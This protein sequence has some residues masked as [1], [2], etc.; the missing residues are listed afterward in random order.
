VD[1]HVPVLLTHGNYDTMRP[2]VV[3][4]MKEKLPRV[5]DIM[6]HKSG[7]LSMIDEPKVMNDAMA[8]FFNRV[9]QQEGYLPRDGDDLSMQQQ[10]EEG[11]H[12]AL[13]RPDILIVLF[14]VC[15][16][17]LFLLVR[18]VVSS[19]RRRLDYAPVVSS[20]LF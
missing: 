18:H 19:R 9:E 12:A 17:G 20:T 11:C 7:H 14:L 6:F 8:D 13:S 1:I 10:H 16:L 4:A 5:E 15:G 3:Q 2:A